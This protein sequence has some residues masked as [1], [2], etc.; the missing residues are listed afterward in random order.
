MKKLLKS[1]LFFFILGAVIFSTVS[2]FAYSYLAGDIGFTPTDTS[3]KKQ[4][5][6][7]ITNVE[8]ALN[9]I[10]TTFEL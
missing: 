1:R 6:G 2:V 8:E 4:G 10:K 3:W 7:D 5:G 9:R